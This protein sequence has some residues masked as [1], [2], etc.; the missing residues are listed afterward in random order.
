MS[1]SV[2]FDLGGQGLGP[3]QRR[4]SMLTRELDLRLFSQ[5]AQGKKVMEVKRRASPYEG[6]LPSISLVNRRLCTA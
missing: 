4:M 3:T 5:Y 2:N 1:A 6:K